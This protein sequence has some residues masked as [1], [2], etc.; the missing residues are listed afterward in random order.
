MNSDTVIG[1]CDSGKCSACGACINICPKGCISYYKKETGTKV[2]V[3]DKNKCIDCHLCQKVCAQLN[4]AEGKEPSDCYA[5]WSLDYTTRASSASGGIAAELYRF[6]SEKEYKLVGVL[7]TPEHTAEFSI[8]DCLESASAYRNSKYVYSNVGN[9]Y[10]EIGK[11]L[12]NQQGVFFVGLPCQV[13]ALKKYLSVKKIP[14]KL[15]FIVDLVCHG[16]TPEQF[17]SEHIAYIEKKKNRKAIHVEFRDPAEKTASFTFS[18]KDDKNTFYKRKVKTDDVYQIGYH[19]GIT[20][21]DNCYSCRFATR[22]RQ[23]D[24]TL[25]DFSYVGCCEPCSYSNENVS[26]V[27]VNSEKGKQLFSTLCGTGRIFYE[28]RPLE[29]ELT[30]EKQLNHPTQIPPE[31]KQFLE[32]IKRHQGFEKAMKCAAQKRIVM[33][34][35]K[36]VMHTDEIRKAISKGIPPSIKKSIKKVLRR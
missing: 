1:V 6:F 31:R 19:A 29:E 25:A 32:G 4:M 24:I 20:Y 30:T 28:K 18:L 13:A 15:L 7:M 35:L 27:L 22:K 23:G 33:N 34:T 36:N 21:R 16:T 11:S 8:S 14:E 12:L 2:A 3:I 26:C 5:A 9:I 17:L 10:S